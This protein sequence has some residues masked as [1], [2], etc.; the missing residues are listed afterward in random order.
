MQKR[1]ERACVDATLEVAIRLLVCACSSIVDVPVVHG[2]HRLRIG[3]GNSVTGSTLIARRDVK[4]DI[5]RE[6]HA[7]RLLKWH[8]I[9]ILGCSGDGQ[10]VCSG[11]RVCVDGLGVADPLPFHRLGDGA[12]EP[13]TILGEEVDHLFRCIAPTF[14]VVGKRELDADATHGNLKEPAQILGTAKPGRSVDSLA[15]VPVHITNLILI[16]YKKL[17]SSRVSNLHS[18]VIRLDAAVAHNPCQ[19]RL[20]EMVGL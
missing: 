12:E 3:V 4:R 7:G 14:R 16:L 15:R 20:L 2:A 19:S 13:A 18:E 9:W 5:V 6:R 10:L 11:C 17:G 8:L 1:R